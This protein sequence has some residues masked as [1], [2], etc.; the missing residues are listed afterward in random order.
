MKVCV[1]TACGNKKQNTSML[2]GNYTNH[3]ELQQYTIVKEIM[4]CIF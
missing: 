3:L 1:V 4:I 2:L